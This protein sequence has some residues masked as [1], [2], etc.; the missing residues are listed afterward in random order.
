MNVW[1]I[2][3]GPWDRPYADVFLRYDVGLIGPGDLGPWTPERDQDPEFD[4]RVKNFA[5]QPSIG[6]TVLLRLGQNRVKAIGAI[7][8]EYLYLDQFDDVNGWDLH[9]ARRVRWFEFPEIQEL[10]PAVFGANPQSFSASHKSEVLEFCQKVRPTLPSTWATQHLANLPE[11]EPV[12]DE[13]QPEIQPL[14]AEVADLWPQFWNRDL[15]DT[16]PSEDETLA[17]LVVPF[18]RA[19]GWSPERIGVK[20]RSIDVAIFERL[21]RTPENC[22]FVVEAKRFRDGV[23]GA[24]EQARGYVEMLGVPRDVIVTDGIRYRLYACA[25]AYKPAAYANL[26]RLKKSAT[27]LFDRV[28]KPPGA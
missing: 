25:R 27:E 14:V 5:T 10:P 16:R 19:F 15:F 26:G 7:A 24:L 21:P 22:R 2:G 17:H 23:E 13:V 28:R 4:S 20:W 3:G 11:P 6:D 9:H 8:S 18:F 1:Q 12:L